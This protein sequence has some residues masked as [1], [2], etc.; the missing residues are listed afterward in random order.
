MKKTLFL[1]LLTV[2]VV[3]CKQEPGSVSGVVTVQEETIGKKA[4]LGAKVYLTQEN[5][6]TLHL[7]IEALDVQEQE[8][9]ITTYKGF[10]EE[11]QGLVDEANKEKINERIVLMNKRIDVANET[12]GI[13]NKYSNGKASE[14]V[15]DSVSFSNIGEKAYA[16]FFNLQTDEKT[17]KAVVDGSGNYKIENVAPGK[18]SIIIVS[19]RVQRTN[20]IDSSGKVTIKPIEVKSKENTTLNIDLSL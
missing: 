4:D 20:L 6:D 2:L 17:L 10:I 1:A 19:A 13:I 9:I 16:K 3:S 7:Y 11:Y 8:K 15:K 18:Y 12:I 14:L 5:T